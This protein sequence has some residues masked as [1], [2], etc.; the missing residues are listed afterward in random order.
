MSLFDTPMSNNPPEIFNDLRTI[1]AVVNM[2]RLNLNR[3]KY[4]AAYWGQ[5]LAGVEKALSNAPDNQDYTYWRSVIACTLNDDMEEES[6]REDSLLG[7]LE[8]QA[9]YQ[10]EFFVLY[11]RTPHGQFTQWLDACP[12]LG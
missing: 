4:F 7:A 6:A 2:C 8:L 9:Y 12:W 3:A 5:L 10:S 1:N 11:L